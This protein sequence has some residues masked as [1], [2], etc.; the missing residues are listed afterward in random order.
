MS[1]IE[2]EGKTQITDVEVMSDEIQSN[3]ISKWVLEDFESKC[4]EKKRLFE[5]EYNDEIIDW[6][7]SLI[8]EW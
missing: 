6:K 4:L 7:Y 5:E 1:E 2:W 3:E 8:T